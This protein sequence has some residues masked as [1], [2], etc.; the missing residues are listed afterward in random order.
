MSALSFVFDFSV[1]LDGDV[2]H[3][4]S[5]STPTSITI[6]DLYDVTKT[7]AASTTVTVWD[8]TLSG[9]PASPASFLALVLLSDTDNVE[10]EL[11]CNEDDANEKEFSITLKAGVPFA[12]G[13]DA[14]R[15]NFTADS[16]GGTLDVID[17]IR[18][19]NLNAD[20]SAKLRVWIAV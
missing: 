16:F 15:F 18:A 9:A 8:P 13:D 10:I 4:A 7:I 2:R 19:K 6:T 3:L 14:S 5:E 1:D 17:K 20:V 11:T 12:L